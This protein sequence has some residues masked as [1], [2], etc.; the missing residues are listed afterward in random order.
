MTTLSKLV[1][2]VIQAVQDV[3]VDLIRDLEKESQTLGRIGDSFGQILHRL[4]FTV[5]SLRGIGYGGREEGMLYTF[6]L[7]TI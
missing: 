5:F 4:N 3:N 7:H 2:S 6:C 1:V